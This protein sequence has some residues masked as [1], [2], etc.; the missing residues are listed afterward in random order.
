MVVPTLR[1]T[2]FFLSAV[3]PVPI[4]LLSSTLYIAIY[5]LREA[6][7]YVKNK[8]PAVMTESNGNAKLHFHS[9]GKILKP[10]FLR[11]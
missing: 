2:H 3:F 4:H 10:L 5:S 7:F 9:L 11:Q 8:Q 6:L 1:Y